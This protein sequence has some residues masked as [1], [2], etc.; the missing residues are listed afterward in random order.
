MP[1]PRFRY[2]IDALRVDGTQSADVRD[3][4]DYSERVPVGS[5]LHAYVTAE[6]AGDLAPVG[7]R[8]TRGK[9]ARWP[10]PNTLLLTRGPTLLDLRRWASVRHVVVDSGGS[11]RP[12][13]G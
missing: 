13:E 1:L 5:E 4:A 3:Y 6:L 7:M 10:L 9:I 12:A 8:V 11:I 2:R